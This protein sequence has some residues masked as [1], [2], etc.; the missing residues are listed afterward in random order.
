MFQ[1]ETLAFDYDFNSVKS[2]EVPA[3]VRAIEWLT[4]TSKLA[5]ANDKEIKIFKVAKNF[6]QSEASQ[7]LST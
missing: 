2:Y 7:K 1:C 4:D 5:V 6:S 3:A